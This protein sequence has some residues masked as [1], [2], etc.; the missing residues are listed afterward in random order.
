M[1]GSTTD[2]RFQKSSKGWKHMHIVMQVL[3]ARYQSLELNL[4]VF[5]EVPV[6]E[7]GTTDSN[8]PDQVAIEMHI[9]NN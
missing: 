5:L 3:A 2:P 4:I 7:I 8:T 1:G 6:E 9:Y